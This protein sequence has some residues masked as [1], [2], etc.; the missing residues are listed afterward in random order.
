VETKK[1]VKIS[2]DKLK[3]WSLMIRMILQN[4]NDTILTALKLWK[5]NIDE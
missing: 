5:K 4:D 2:E 3:K 1:G